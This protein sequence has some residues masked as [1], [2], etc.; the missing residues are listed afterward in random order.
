[1]DFTCTDMMQLSHIDQ[2]VTLHCMTEHKENT[3]TL[4]CFW[5]RENRDT[6]RARSKAVQLE[7]QEEL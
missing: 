5:C 6:F 7:E 4:I 2:K 1:M 3:F